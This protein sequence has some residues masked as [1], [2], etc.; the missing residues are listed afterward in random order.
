MFA[1]ETNDNK[2]D[3]HGSGRQM[4]CLAAAPVPSPA[5]HVAPWWQVG[6]NF[7][8]IDYFH[9]IEIAIAPA[10]AFA[11]KRALLWVVRVVRMRPNFRAGLALL[12]AAHN[13]TWKIYCRKTFACSCWCA[14]PVNCTYQGGA[15]A[16]PVEGRLQGLRN[17]YV[18]QIEHRISFNQ[19]NLCN[20]NCHLRRR[21]RTLSPRT[22]C[23]Q[24]T[25]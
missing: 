19:H 18:Y 4:E 16:D 10:R 6:W 24:G 23:G 25:D 17:V 2:H 5:Q 11:R 15:K 22:S 3:K 13:S 9:S 8:V 7:Q 21:D 14:L 20:S 1:R 12:T